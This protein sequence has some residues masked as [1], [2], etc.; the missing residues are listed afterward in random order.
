MTKIDRAEDSSN[1]GF[2]HLELCIPASIHGLL[3][4][5]AQFYGQDLSNMVLNMVMHEVDGELQ[6]NEEMGPMIA[7]YLRRKYNFKESDAA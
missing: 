7:K 3:K 6:N 5:M 4:E 2:V 1:R